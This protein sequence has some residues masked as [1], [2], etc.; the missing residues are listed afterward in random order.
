MIFFIIVNLIVWG[1]VSWCQASADHANTPRSIVHWLEIG[2]DGRL[3]CVS[4]PNLSTSELS[5]LRDSGD[6]WLDSYNVQRDSVR[7]EY[8]GFEADARTAIQYGVDKWLELVEVHYPLWIRFRSVP[9]ESSA[10]P[11]LAVT[12]S[13]TV[14]N[15]LPGINSCL[16]TALFNQIVRDRSF[17][18][19]DITISIIDLGRHRNNWYLG[20]DGNTP[21]GTYD[22][23]T[24]QIRTRTTT[25]V[26]VRA[27]SIHPQRRRT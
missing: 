18:D 11:Y 20:T 26:R 19:P 10:L 22:L 14:C 12:F 24:I 21:R 17:G 16:T 7:V 4:E 15:S 3:D 2:P 9:M 25:R 6:S 1:A 5:A 8:V 23:P 27:G 13:L